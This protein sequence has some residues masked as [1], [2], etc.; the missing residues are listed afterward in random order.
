MGGVPREVK[1]APGD[2]V[3]TLNVEDISRIEF[4]AP[5]A[6]ST[7]EKAGAT[8]GGLM[9]PAGTNIVIRMIDGVDSERNSVGQTFAA[10]LDK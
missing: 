4:D 7:G 10:S 8:A 2:Q 3:R 6:A 9:V 5:P 1:I